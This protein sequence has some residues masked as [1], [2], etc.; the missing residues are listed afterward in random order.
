MSNKNFPEINLAPKVEKVIDMK[1][2]GFKLAYSKSSEYSNGYPLHKVIYDSEWCRIQF[3]AYQR[4]SSPPDMHD[5]YVW[6]G[7]LHAPDEGEKMTWQGEECRCWHSIGF[8]HLF[9]LEG[10]SP[11]ET[12]NH[13]S[14]AV[15]EKARSSEY[16]KIRSE[17]GEFSPIH[18][19]SLIW[20]QY[21][22]RLFE[23]F[24]LRHTDL[25]DKYKIFL[26]EYYQKSSSSLWKVC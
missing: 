13:P 5:V 18:R 3:A 23:L 10:L 12:L 25:W 4:R 2:W 14:L 1:Q 15:F 24:D 17:L 7:R 22:L 19:E 9:F 26:K 20:E 6:Y 16:D 21:G 11:S 8:T